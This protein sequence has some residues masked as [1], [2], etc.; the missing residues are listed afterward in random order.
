V[1]K[2]LPIRIVTHDVDGNVTKTEEKTD[3]T[4]AP[5]L[6]KKVKLNEK[7]GA[8]GVQELVR[9][10]REELAQEPKPDESDN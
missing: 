5:K 2:K 9:S 8:F 4:D 10:K 1:A 3:A 7:L 6:G